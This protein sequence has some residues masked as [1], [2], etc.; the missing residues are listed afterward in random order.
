MQASPQQGGQGLEIFVEGRDTKPQS[1]LNYPAVVLV[2]DNWDDYG[3]KTLFYATLYVSESESIELGGVKILRYQYDTEPFTTKLRKRL[4]RLD[5]EFCSLGDSLDYYEH[6][7]DIEPKIRDT[8]LRSMND[9]VFDDKIRTR[10]ETRPGFATSLLRSSSAAAALEN[11]S[12]LMF[13]ERKADQNLQ[14]IYVT[15]DEA[16]LALSFN[17]GRTLPGRMNAIIGYNG[18]GKTTVLAG[19][20]QVAAST[21]QRRSDVDIAAKYGRFEGKLQRFATTIAVSYSA[22]DTFEVP[23][24]GYA[25]QA[26]DVDDE[27]LVGYFYCGLRRYGVGSTSDQLKSESD[28]LAELREAVSLI[29]TSARRE[30]LDEALE[31]LLNEPSFRRSGTDFTFDE[32]SWEEKFKALSSGHQIALAIIVQ[33]VTHMKIGSLALIDEPES[34]LHPPLLAA[35]MRGIGVALEKTSSF[36]VIAT[37]SPVVI[38]EVPKACVHVLRRLGEIRKF[39]APTRETYGENLG[40]LTSE[41]FNLDNVESSYEGVLHTMASTLSARQIESLFPNGLS[42]QARSILM[43]EGVQF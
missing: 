8:Y 3:Y 21:I 32:N 5:A 35:L 41:V 14:L 39:E 38:Q 31:P 43:Q 13:P 33:L 15:P 40:I 42:G 19:I 6:L 18:V 28:R 29:T 37:H 24:V 1:L 17:S 12:I 25:N 22:F 11:A 16:V 30:A 20:A 9:V 36:A 4:V 23:P 2:K 26:E 27:E 34:H 7:N 10:F